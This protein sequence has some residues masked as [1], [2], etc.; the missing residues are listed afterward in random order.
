MIGPERNNHGHSV[1]NTLIN[2]VAYDNL[3]YHVDYDSKQ[4]R[5][6]KSQDGQLLLRHALS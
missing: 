1:L 4:V 2:Q 3:Y 6:R 5:K